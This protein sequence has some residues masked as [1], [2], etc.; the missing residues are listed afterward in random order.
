MMTPAAFNPMAMWGR[1]FGMP[2]VFPGL[3]WPMPAI[4]MPIS[5]LPSFA[6]GFGMLDMMAPMLEAFAPKPTRTSRYH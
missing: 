3:G 6:N 1:P 4:G 5:P 2:G